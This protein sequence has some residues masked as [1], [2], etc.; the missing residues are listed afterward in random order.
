MY[1]VEG[2]F[3]E[4]PTEKT[5]WNSR[6]SNI[7]IVI[8]WGARV[9]RHV[10]RHSDFGIETGYSANGSKGRGFQVFR[11]YY[12]CKSD[13][14]MSA[15]CSLCGD[16][17]PSST[18]AWHGLMAHIRFG[19]H[20]ITVIQPYANMCVCAR[21]RAFVHHLMSIRL[22]VCLCVRFM[23]CK[24]ILSRTMVR[25]LYSHFHDQFHCI[26]QFWFVFFFFLFCIA[27]TWGLR[28]PF[29]LLLF[30]W[31]QMKKQKKIESK[32]MI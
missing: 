2:V 16:K 28:S 10:Q 15:G 29:Y 11:H 5:N 19:S 24:C 6:A 21:A 18:D 9:T 17:L 14:L 26:I 13:D 31:R 30:G 4:A 3:L 12:H 22:C 8:L 20:V 32:W 25:L 1:D 27:R 23:H 7:F